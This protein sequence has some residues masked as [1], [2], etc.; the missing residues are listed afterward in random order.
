MTH[1]LFSFQNTQIAEF[2]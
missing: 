1:L 2:F